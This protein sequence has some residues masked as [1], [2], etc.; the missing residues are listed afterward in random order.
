MVPKEDGSHSAAQPSKC[1]HKLPK[2][3]Q[4]DEWEMLDGIRVA[5]CDEGRGSTVK[6]KPD[7]CVNVRRA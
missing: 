1:R 7:A 2:N 5:S 3:E 4:A 6:P